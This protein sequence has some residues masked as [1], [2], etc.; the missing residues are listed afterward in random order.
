MCGDAVTFFVETVDVEWHAV[1]QKRFLGVGLTNQLFQCRVFYVAFD[2]TD[3]E[4]C[5]RVDDVDD[6]DFLAF[7]G[8]VELDVGVHVSLVIHHLSQILNSA[9]CFILVVDDGVLS[10]FAEQTCGP[11]GGVD[12]SEA[13]DLKRNFRSEPLAVGCLQDV[14]VEQQVF[15]RFLVSRNDVSL[16]RKYSSSPTKRSTEQLV[17]NRVSS[18]TAKVHRYGLKS[19]ASHL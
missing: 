4:L 19:S 16:F 10:D 14:V 12:T 9:F 17:A 6:V 3:S 7:D 8:F 15:R 11:V 2:V 1:L 5:T 18:R 13:V